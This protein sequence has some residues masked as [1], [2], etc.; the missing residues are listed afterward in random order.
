MPADREFAI[1]VAELRRLAG[2]GDGAK[3]DAVRFEKSSALAFTESMIVTGGR[4]AVVDMP[5]YAF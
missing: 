5:V 4:W 2:E 1:D 3:P